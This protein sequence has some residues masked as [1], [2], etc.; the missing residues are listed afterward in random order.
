MLIHLTSFLRLLYP[1]S[2]HPSS[3]A[4]PEAHPSP[5]SLHPGL[6]GYLKHFQ[7]IREDGDY[8]KIAKLMR[9]SNLFIHLQ[10]LFCL[11]KLLAALMDASSIFRNLFIIPLWK[12][13]FLRVSF[14]RLLNIFKCGNGRRMRALCGWFY[15]FIAA[16]VKGNEPLWSFLELS[17]EPLTYTWGRWVSMWQKKRSVFLHN[18]RTVDNSKIKFKQEEWGISACLLW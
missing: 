13:L 7:V 17:T 18:N 16:D 6:P 3:V 11:T 1:L 12:V 15:E 4:Y 10:V 14:S 8:V 2:V 9:T 5:G